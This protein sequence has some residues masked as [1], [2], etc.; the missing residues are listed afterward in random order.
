ML[1]SGSKPSNHCDHSIESSVTEEK[2]EQENNVED[3]GNI[4][5]LPNVEPPENAGKEKG[6]KRKISQEIIY[7]QE[8]KNKRHIERIN[9]E[10]EKMM[11]EKEKMVLLKAYLNSKN[12]Q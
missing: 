9:L 2:S 6:K 3:S 8:Q 1:V 5:D 12:S 4:I 11:L 10:R 7:V